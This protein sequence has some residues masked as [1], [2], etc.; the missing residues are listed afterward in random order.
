MSG[1]GLVPPRMV[2]PKWGYGMAPITPEKQEIRE[3]AVRQVLS[4]RPTHRLDRSP[5]FVQSLL[6]VKGLFTRA[7]RQNRWD[8]FTVWNQLGRP[9]RYQSTKIDSEFYKVRKAAQLQNRAAGQT[10]MRNLEDLGAFK[11]LRGFLSGR[12]IQAAL[13]DGHGQVYIL[14]TREQRG[15]LKIGFTN[16]HVEDRVKQ[17]NSATGVAIPWGVRGVWIVKDAKGVEGKVH[18]KLADRRLRPDRE[19]FTVDF[20]E[21]FDVIQGVILN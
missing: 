11:S 18:E 16:G 14:E 10:G 3:Q 15:L 6:S 5:E 20:D 17:I 7:S 2:H 1:D 9:G 8:W 13:P 21:A 12:N 19:F 4:L